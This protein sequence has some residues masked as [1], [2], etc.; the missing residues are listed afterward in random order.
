MK[1]NGRIGALSSLALSILLLTFF[2]TKLAKIIGWSIFIFS[3]LFL[4]V[5]L[6]NAKK[7]KHRKYK[8]EQKTKLICCLSNL[9]LKRKE[10]INSLNESQIDIIR[11]F[12]E[13]FGID[14][15]RENFPMIEKYLLY[16]PTGAISIA[17]S[18][19][20]ANEVKI[21]NS[22]E[23]AKDIIRHRK[24][25]KK[26]DVKKVEE[27]YET[28][29]ENSFKIKRQYEILISILKEMPLLLEVINRKGIK[30]YNISELS[31]LLKNELG[32]MHE[33]KLDRNGEKLKQS[34]VDLMDILNNVRKEK[35]SNKSV[36]DL[37]YTYC[38]AR[39]M[40]GRQYNINRISEIEL[41]EDFVRRCGWAFA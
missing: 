11:R 28:I 10:L 32:K 26:A 22:I 14:C 35:L 6:V 18:D 23:K 30:K 27:W 7:I 39:N 24:K 2:P 16:G 38:M 19:M 17:E 36:D 3:I 25:Y 34:L 20:S 40:A 13:R 15:L 9:I 1:K 5:A 8:D 12:I 37:I 41:C 21:S 31:F 29:K 33:E 4:I